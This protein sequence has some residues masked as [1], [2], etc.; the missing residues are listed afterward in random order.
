MRPL[1]FLALALLVA[2]CTA[3]G[4][5][6]SNFELTPQK[7]GWYAGDDATFT[8]SI[9]SSL[10]RSEPSFTIDRRFALEEVMLNER[11]VRF[12]GDHSTRDPDSVA[13]R[14]ESGGVT[15]E[16]WTLDERRP[17]V[18]VTLT[19]P[20]TLKDSEYALELK[21]FEVGWVKSAPFRVDRR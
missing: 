21:V 17:A 10:L 2:G 5:G 13:L 1:A 8:L 15:A 9:T 12:G 6:T 11:G 18:N 3:E 19:L 16:E 7:V 20:D 14:L 4:A